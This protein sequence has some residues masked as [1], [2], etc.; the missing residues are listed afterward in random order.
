MADKGY[1][2]DFHASSNVKG[3]DPVCEESAQ[4]GDSFS[5]TT[6]MVHHL[7]RRLQLHHRKKAWN[8]YMDNYFTT[9]PLLAEL[10][11]MGVGG[12]VTAKANLKG[13][14][15]EFKVVTKQSK[16]DY[17]FRSGIVKDGVGCLLWMDSAPVMM[18][19]TIHSLKEQEVKSRWHPGKK[20]TNAVAA[21]EFYQDKQ[22]MDLLVPIIV[23]AYN[24]YK[25]GVD[26]A[27]QYRTYYDTQLTSRRNWYPLFYWALETAIDHLSGRTYWQ[28]R[29]FGLSFGCCLD[30]D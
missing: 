26:V 9:V 14:P 15:E 13:Y 22:Q 21:N 19:S 30:V 5:N 2:W 7:V 24:M 28:C 17:Q 25:V 29:P 18:M 12:C 10:R 6:K 11:R 20:S 4:L 3:L 23:L 16:L 27:D 8:V 1:V